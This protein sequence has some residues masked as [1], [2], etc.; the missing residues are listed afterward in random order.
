MLISILAGL[1]GAV[2]L[3]AGI[4]EGVSL[5]PAWWG[6]VLTLTYLLQAL[7]SHLLERRYEPDMLRSLFWVIWYPAAFWLISFATTVV[8]V[9]KAL[10]GRKRTR[11]TWVS[12]D[13]GLR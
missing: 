5:I 1:A 2:G 13:R 8:A 12:P 11:G 10:L 7:V 3:D 4:V 6:V 9:P